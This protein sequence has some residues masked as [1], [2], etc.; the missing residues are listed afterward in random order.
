MAE[1]CVGEACMLLSVSQWLA[2]NLSY[3]LKIVA[4]ADLACSGP[5]WKKIESVFASPS[6][7]DVSFLKQQVGT[8]I[9]V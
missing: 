2:V 1:S 5:F 8:G 3:C 7:E 6:I 9:Y 4:F